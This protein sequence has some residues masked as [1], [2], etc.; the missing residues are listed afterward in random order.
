MEP[1]IFPSWAS[2]VE[3]GAKEYRLGERPL[4]ARLGRGCYSEFY[5]S[6]S[7]MHLCIL[8]RQPTL[9]IYI[10]AVALSRNCRIVALAALR[11]AI[12]ELID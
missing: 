9:T 5:Q 8:D 12:L 3:S 11:H 4:S 2:S 7:R 6:S 10:L 1:T